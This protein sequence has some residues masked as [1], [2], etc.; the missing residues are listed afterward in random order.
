MTKERR[1]YFKQKAKELAAKMTTDEMIGIICFESAPV[2]RLG[3]HAYNWW[4]EASHG[5]A[6][7]GA[8]TVFPCPT[9]LAA[10]GDE[11]LLFKIGEAVADEARAKYNMYAERGEYDIYKGLTF[12][13]PNVNIFRDPRWGRGQET[14]GEDPELTARLAVAYIKGLQGDGDFLKVSACAKHFAVHSGPEKD[15]HEFNAVVSEEDLRNTYLPAFKACVDAGV[16]GVMGAYNRLYGEACCASDVLSKILFDEWGFDGYFMSDSCA[17]NNIHEC[18]KCTKDAAETAA[19][20][21]K[22]G[23]SLDCSHIYRD[24]MK[25]ALDRGLVTEEEIRRAAEKTLE[26][27]AMLGEFEEERPFKDVSWDVLCCPEH[28]ALNLEAACSS[29]V[30]LEN[31]NAVPLNK[32][33]YKRIAVVGPNADSRAVLTGNYN[34][35]PTEYITV[36]EGIR[37]EF[38]KAQIRY[39]PGCKLFA[40][41]RN[42]VYGFGDMISEAVEE[43]KRADLTVLCLGLDAGYEGE[44]NLIYNEVTASGDRLT[45]G[46]P[47]TQKRL[48]REVLAVTGNVIVITFCGGC[49]DIGDVARDKCLAHIH[50]WYPGELGG[51]AIAKCLAG[52]HPFTGRTPVTF[53]REDA[54]L[55]DFADYSMAHRGKNADPDTVLYPFGYGLITE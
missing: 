29:L 50:A 24:H 34:G 19:A 4:N 14:F 11:E 26:I 39:S 30:L 51:E 5:V 27:R 32:D 2:E 3:I 35:H 23:I 49:I 22:H 1:K 25:E 41:D 33:T 13:C 12:W 7:N 21:L 45:V 18:H 36:L 46:L 6:R 40:E 54:P 8:A 55:P 48:L 28:R 37:R 44:E 10:T 15:R 17:L 52:E 16:T 42:C 31:K 9:A 53:Y 20:A 47:N 38:P 43:A